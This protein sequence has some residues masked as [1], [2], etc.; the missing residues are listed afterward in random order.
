MVPKLKEKALAKLL[1]F[2]A[3]LFRMVPKLGI[4]TFNRDKC[5]RAVLFR[6]VPKQMDKNSP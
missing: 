2:R 6:M 5:F 3:V 1:G 4:K